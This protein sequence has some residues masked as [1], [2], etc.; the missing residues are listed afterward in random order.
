MRQNSCV[1]CEFFKRISIGEQT[2]PSPEDIKGECRFNPPASSRYYDP[3]IGD[4][5]TQTHYPIV[6]YWDYCAQYR[7]K[8]LFSI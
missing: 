7:E 3:Q 6:G 2:K 4:V 1:H 8:D 5:L